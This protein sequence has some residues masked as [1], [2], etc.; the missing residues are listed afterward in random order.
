MD[1]DGWITKVDASDGYIRYRV[2]FKNIS[3]WT[4]DFKNILDKLRVNTGELRTV[5]NNRSSKKAYTFTINS[6]DYCS[7]VGFS[8]DRKNKI[9]KSFM[10][11]YKNNGNRNNKKDNIILRVS[12][13]DHN[14]IKVK[15][16][17]FNRKK[18]DYIRHCI[19]SHWENMDDTKHFKK[20]L[21][22]Y[23][24][25]EKDTKKQVVEMFFQYYRR[26]GFPY[27]ILTNE[28]K[29]N[30]MKRIISSN[31][32]LLENDNLQ[33]N[34]NGLDLANSFHPH[35]IEAYY[36]RGDN[37]PL[38]SFNNDD[39]LRDCINRWLEL[40]KTPNHAGI[41]RIL[42]T[43]DGTRGVVN[44]KPTIA[45]FIYDNHCPENG[46]VL[47][48]CAGYG[49]RLAGCISSNR[50][51]FYHGIDP[52]GKTSVGNM[53]M[54]NFFSTQYDALGERVYEY[55]FRFDMGMAEEVMPELREEYDLVF[56]SPPY[57]NVEIY[58]GESSQSCNKYDSY[59]SWLY[60][61]LYV[62]IDQSKKILK[63]GGYLVLNVKNTEKYKIADDLCNYCEK[64]WR[65]EKIYHMRLANS[66]YN[67]RK[68]NTY[69]VEP[70]FIFRK[71]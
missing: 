3:G 2:G 5:S 10:D 35:M 25:G 23:Q 16:S 59:K 54:A 60:S 50:N 61:F 11:F 47:D 32:I 4:R 17:L 18:S 38:V 41:R 29:E 36:K 9:A 15:S 58:S 49:G 31:S 24:E 21:K 44:F 65:L 64:D 14:I 63:D 70:I 67:R 19:M 6:L 43:R 40:G 1:S 52:N 30:R 45:K 71:K 51:I 20:M 57:F 22:I 66:S 7:K 13:A 27:V 8:I 42:K 26:N 28:Q 12:N 37:S 48:P 69:H 56:T 46:K 39:N 34:F 33:M 53:K 62:I 68:N 55:R